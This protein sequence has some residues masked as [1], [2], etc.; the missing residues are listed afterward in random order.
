MSKA[1]LII[2]F[3][4]SSFQAYSQ[5]DSDLLP[6]D[7][8]LNTNEKKGPNK[9]VKTIIYATGYAGATLL[10]YRYLDTDIKDFAQSNQNE[11]VTSVAETFEQLGTGTANII[12]TAATG[13]TSLITKNKKLQKTTILL[14][15]GHIINDIRYGLTE[16]IYGWNSVI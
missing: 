13:V 2:W 15:G 7:T 6:K 9:A 12:I 1:A 14:I 3:V 11:T 8:I 10:C 4:L 16:D 5:N